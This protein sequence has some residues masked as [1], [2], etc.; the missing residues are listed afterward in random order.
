MI[1][2]ERLGEE[3]FTWFADQSS[4]PHAVPPEQSIAHEYAE[5]HDRELVKLLDAKFSVRIP[6]QWTEAHLAIA[7]GDV[8][9]DRAAL[10][11]IAD[12]YADVET[13][14]WYEPS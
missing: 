3:F 2:D 8:P 9:D 12:E 5:N 11:A 14:W 1:I 4:R 13:P 7:V 6:Q 10:H